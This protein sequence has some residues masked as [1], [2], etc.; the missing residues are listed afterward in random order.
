MGQDRLPVLKA[1]QIILVLERLGFKHRKLKATSH[2]RYFH[3]N[4]R[5]TNIPI[6][7]GQDIGRGLLRKIL[8]D[9]EISP[10]EFRELL[11]K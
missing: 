7:P 3:S 6:H 10:E 1:R 5:K 9:I 11:Q 2:R 4:G 8:K